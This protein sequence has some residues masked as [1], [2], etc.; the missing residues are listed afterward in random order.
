MWC[1]EEMRDIEPAPPSQRT[2]AAT[3][4]GNLRRRL[5]SLNLSRS[6]GY[7]HELS[8]GASPVV[9]Y[10]PESERH[11]NFIEASYRA[12]CAHPAWR[13]RLAKAHTSKRQARPVGQDE[14]IRP[15]CEL[16]SANS[17]DA[18]LMNIFCYPRAL[19]SPRLATLLGV[20]PG[21]EPVFGH[22]ARIPLLRDRTDGTEVDMRLGDLLVEAKLT[23]TDFQFAPLRR[24]QN[25]AAFNEVFHRDLIEVTTRG[26]RS[27]QL[28]RG[29]LAAHAQ[30]SANFCVVCDAERPD[31]IEAWYAIIR[32]VR[33]F[34]LQ[35]RLR[36]LTWQEVASTVPAPLRM[37]LAE[38]Y[39]IEPQ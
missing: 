33:S 25:Y 11:G 28:I 17:S 37:F 19:A 9:I 7:P 4:A 8:R 31:L 15:W 32:A 36:L 2:G 6:A 20:E 5:S 35:S 16:D 34:Q 24:L 10:T 26:L 3:Y 13:R 29:V 39:G 22:P 18:L 12:I 14:L 21:L 30:P 38:K 23:E 27:Y 1:E